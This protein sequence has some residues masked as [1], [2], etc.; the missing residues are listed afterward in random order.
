[1][2]SSKPALYDLYKDILTFQDPELWFRN[3][4]CFVHLYTRGQ[5][6]RG[7][8]FK[9][10]FSTLLAAQCHPLVEHFIARDMSTLAN[11]PGTHDN[12]TLQPMPT[13][14]PLATL[15]YWSRAHLLGR[16][17]LYI[18]PPLEADKDQVYSYYLAIRNLFAWIFRR[19]VV[20]EHLGSAL[21][22]LFSAMREFRQ[23]SADNAQDLMCYLEDEGYLAVSGQPE[24]ALALLH[25][26][27]TMHMRDLYITSF[28]HCVGMYNELFIGTEH[29]VSQPTAIPIY[30]KVANISQY[31]SAAS[32]KRIRRA[33]LDMDLRLGSAGSMLCNFLQDELS[34]THL[35]LPAQSRTHLDRFRAFIR[36]Y[37]TTRLGFYPPIS[38]DARSTIFEPQVYRLVAEDFRA[39]F[40]YLVDTSFLAGSTESPLSQ[41]GFCVLQ[42]INDFDARHKYAPQRHPLPLLPDTAVQPP[43]TSASNAATNTDAAS[44]GFLGVPMPKRSLST[45]RVPWFGSKKMDKLLQTR[46]EKLMPDTR[47]V[48]NAS[49]LKATNKLRPDMARSDF[50][51]AYRQFEEDSVFK[52]YKADR[53]EKI[54]LVE[55]RKVRWILVYAIHQTLQNCFIPP[56]LQITN[57]ATVRYHMS[58]S[59]KYIPEWKGGEAG[60]Q[61]SSASAFSSP[62]VSPTSGT[63]P[64]LRT[65]TNSFTFPATENLMPEP[66]TPTSRH[67][68]MNSALNTPTPSLARCMSMTALPDG[69]H[70]STILMMPDRGRTASPVFDIR[71]DIDYLG[72]ANRAEPTSLDVEVEVVMLPRSRSLTRTLSQ[73][74]AFRRSLS[75][76]RGNSSNNVYTQSQEPPSPTIWSRVK[77][78]DS[79]AERRSSEPTSLQSSFRAKRNSF[80]MRPSSQSKTEEK[81]KT[82]ERKN[83]PYHEIVVHGYGNG[84]NPVQLTVSTD[85][86]HEP[87]QESKEAEAEEGASPSTPLDD[88][89]AMPSTARSLSTSSTTSNTSAATADT[90]LTAL[91]EA[92]HASSSACPSV[93]R[94]DSATD[95]AAT[96]GLSRSS[97][98]HSSTPGSS[99]AV[100]RTS[101]FVAAAAPAIPPRGGPS[102]DVA[103][104]QAMPLP[105]S[106]S[107]SS[108]VYSTA[109]IMDDALAAGVGRSA[110]TPMSSPS[111]GS[112]RRTPPPPPLPVRSSARHRRFSVYGGGDEYARLNHNLDAL[113]SL[114]SPNSPNSLGAAVPQRSNT[115]A[116]FTSLISGPKRQD[117]QAPNVLQKQPAPPQT[118]TQRRSSLHSATGASHRPQ[119]LYVGSAAQGGQRF[120]MV[121]EALE[122]V[123]ETMEQHQMGPSAPISRTPSFG[124]VA[125]L[126]SVNEDDELA[127]AAPC[128]GERRRSKTLTQPRSSRHRHS[129]YIAPRDDSNIYS[130]DD[131]DDD[132]YMDLTRRRQPQ[133]EHPEWDKFAGLG[134]HTV[135]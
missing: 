86:A 109:S 54:S 82:H 12:T 100:S 59:P 123:R 46:S 65:L 117:P 112:S 14:P 98:M 79:G 71:P 133:S 81:E 19:P 23:A 52:P 56:P 76:F 27:E 44:N 93:T 60:I 106:I 110:T 28:A 6:R 83:S 111:L 78:T 94:T 21:A 85:V 39:L 101:S 42:N 18:P 107:R 4:N 121:Q 55:A 118:Q 92:T 125:A 13:P 68:T 8:A 134:G 67:K 47:L 63:L 36:G 88:S 96:P 3:G 120:D 72:L 9:L 108:S 15:D 57:A 119:S 43:I 11:V 132:F 16:V 37:Y 87:S 64:S 10:P 99:M 20:G 90:A 49:L 104:R 105:A 66:L 103:Q 130:N 74:A 115:A 5:S 53:M 91:T 61:D 80:L 124:G 128:T 84:T 1:M 70:P 129:S 50:L 122:A 31:V 26:A 29:Q 33:R 127:M 38:I 35:G 77:Q 131:D 102:Q 89:A 41:G 126:R 95:V 7:P 113:N 75:L 73:K 62:P 40:E 48:A 116:R 34:E 2:A 135:V 45:R 30:N 69:H 24:Y 97:S 58:I 51:N 25:L 22:G 114:N 17:D 32:R